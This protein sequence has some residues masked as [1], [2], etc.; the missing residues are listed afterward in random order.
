MDLLMS[1]EAQAS[2]GGGRA[3]VLLGNHELMNLIGEQR[4][5]TAEI[6]ATFADGESESRR[7]RAWAQYE[8]LAA[9]RAKVRPTVP[10]VYTKTKD[11]WLAAHPP[12][13]LEYREALS[14][15]GRYGKWLRDKRVSARVDGTL[16]M[17]AGPDPA[18]KALDVEA[19]DT[20]I[21]QELG[22]V[23]RFLEQ[24]VAAKL[25]LPFFSLTELLEAAAGE[26]RAVNAVVAAAKE[27]GEA[28]DLG[29]F[30]IE[31]VKQAADLISIGEWHL[32]NPGGPMWYR[33]YAASPEATLRDPV[34][35]LLAKND[36]TRIV[37]A[38]TPSSERRILTRLG[39]IV[40][41]IDSGM[42]TSAYKGRA[43]ALEIAGN[44]L[45]AIYTDG[46]VPLE[47]AKPSPGGALLL[48]H[49]RQ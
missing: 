27:K 12:G 19:I 15:R 20:Q 7:E 46:R 31:L 14:P 6:Y 35:A 41:L 38:H 42:L 10:E 4:D 13:W 30:D 40:V 32:L 29:D 44:Q 24:A 37:V 26:I 45:T 18:G 36:V 9:L 48:E 33:G 21:R 16:F 23:D 22:R 8:A 5:V 25:A 34:A 39:G 43:S 1:I 2:K 28:P 11:A 49:Q 17:H 3:V 47:T